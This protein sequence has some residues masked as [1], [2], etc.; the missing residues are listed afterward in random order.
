MKPVLH[1]QLLSRL[2]TESKTL[3]IALKVFCFV[4][5][6]CCVFGSEEDGTRWDLLEAHGVNSGGGGFYNQGL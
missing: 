6:I 4:F 2:D 3:D 1:V 5:L